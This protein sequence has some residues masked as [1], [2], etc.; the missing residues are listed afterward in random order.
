MMISA[1]ADGSR[2][3]NSLTWPV[4]SDMVAMHHWKNGGLYGMSKPL[5]IG[6]IQLCWFS[7]DMAT[8]ASRG[9]PLVVKSVLPRN[10]RS[11]NAEIIITDQK[12]NLWLLSIVIG[13]YCFIEL[14][15]RACKITFFF[16]ESTV[17]T[18]ICINFVLWNVL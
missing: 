15:Y 3:V 12:T 13:G 16:Y 18:R 6:R 7:I 4:A 11:V 2:D 8:T 17:L 14:L 10:G 5:L 1:N 9:S